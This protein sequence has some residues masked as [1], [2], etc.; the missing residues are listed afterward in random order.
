MWGANIAKILTI[1][2]MLS[3]RR[4][5]TVEQISE[6]LE[7][8]RTNVYKWLKLIEEEFGF[9]ILDEKDVVEN[10]TRKRLDSDYYHH[11]GIKNLPDF[12]FSPQELIALH[13]LK[14]EARTTHNID[15]DDSI[16]SAF[17]KIG[18]FAP[19]GFAKKLAKLQSLFLLDTKMAKSYTGKQ[20][21]IDQLTNAMLESRTCYVS[22]HSFSDDQDKN[23]RIDPLHFFEHQGGLYLFVKA[24][25]FGDI[26]KL[27]VD[28]IN[29][30]EDAGESF[31]YPEDF[32][33][34]E[35]QKQAF[36]IVSDDP[37]EVEIWFSA[38]QARYIKERQWAEDQEI[39]E[40]E[41]GSIILKMATSGTFEV[42][43]WVLGYGAEAEVLRPIRLRKELATEIKN[44][45]KKYSFPI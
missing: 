39:I 21:I 6:K 29:K 32:D 33:P 25:S 13:F 19:K 37:L 27:A 14:G 34:I 4:G 31:E 24:T 18:M 38:D 16:K 43:R 9:P 35:S 28:R 45:I 20:E 26:L 8:N 11:R 36:G 42:K 1:F 5:A 44:L 2:D 40:Q 17:T 30:V 3:S 23:F 41:D 7:I 10:K 15:L 12:K 22:Y